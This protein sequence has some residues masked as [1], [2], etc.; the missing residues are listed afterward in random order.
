M[1]SNPVVPKQYNDPS[2]ERAFVR[3]DGN[4][5][6]V[7]PGCG[8]VKI[9][10]VG[11][12]KERQHRLQVRCSCSHIF[13]IN[14]D[15]RQCFRKPTNLS[16]I[17]GLHPPAVGGGVVQVLNLSLSGLCFEV[18]GVHKITIGDKGRIDFTLDN[19]KKTRLVREF[20][21]RSITGKMIGC[22]FKKEQQFEKELGFYLRFGP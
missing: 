4:A 8:T 6:I 9:V 16:G 22:Q 19:R 10:P 3:A 7:C 2:A 15:F 17:Y 1:V 12:Y 21:V 20:V 5:T 13:K 14:L 11:Q 18:S